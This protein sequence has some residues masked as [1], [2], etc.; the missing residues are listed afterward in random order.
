MVRGWASSPSM[1]RSVAVLAVAL[2]LVAC[3]T[4]VPVEAKGKGSKGKRKT[5]LGGVDKEYY[6]LRDECTGGCTGGSDVQKENCVLLCV[7][8]ECYEKIYGSDPLEEGELD[9]TRGRLFRT[10]VR[11]K[12]KRKATQQEL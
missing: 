10:C 12:D 1:A 11:T 3:E 6:K 4:A 2:L 9:T 7:S 5:H 8:P